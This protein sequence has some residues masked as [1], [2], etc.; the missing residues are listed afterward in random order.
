MPKL[1]RNRFLTTSS[2]AAIICAPDP[3]APPDYAA[4]AAAQGAANVEAARAGAKLNNPNI[5]NPYGTQTVQYGE[6]FDQS[7]YDAAVAAARAAGEDLPDRTDYVL[8]DPDVGTVFQEFSPEQQG[9]YDRQVQVKTLL[10]DLG[11]QGAQALG[12]TIGAGFDTSSARPLDE[13]YNQE[14]ALNPAATPRALDPNSLS[15]MP[16]NA[17]QTREKVY[18]AMMGR[19]DQDIA[20]Q[21]DQKNSELIAAGIRPGTAA[22][23]SAMTQIDRQQTDARQQALLASGQEASRDYTMDMG[24]RTQGAAEQGQYFGQEMAGGAQDFGQRL[25]ALDQYRIGQNQGYSQSSDARRQQIAEML[26]QRQTPLNE[27]IAMMGGSQ[28]SNPF[29]GNLG[30]QAGAVT[31]PA[32]IMQAT[33]AQ[34]AYDQNAYNQSVAGANAGLSGL[35]SLGAAGITKYSDRRLKRNIRRIGTHSLGIG[36]YEFDYVWGEHATGVMADEVREVMP[37]AVGNVGGYATV[38]YSMLG[39]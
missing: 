6:G 1:N 30:Y 27:I 29:A 23:D 3:P 31:Q 28:V 18:Q 34:G 9:L 37:S 22:Y 32:P 39:A 20:G 24:R 35:F 5:F 12:G 19:V 26:A 11:I 14:W 15:A 17:E 36:L 4:A 21:R 25:S 10:G 38:D 33:Q 8:G 2:G 16:G 13:S 7:G